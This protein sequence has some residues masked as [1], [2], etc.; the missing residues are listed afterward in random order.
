MPAFSNTRRANFGEANRVCARE[1][2]TD[3]NGAFSSRI[4]N[5]ARASLTCPRLVLL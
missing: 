2:N 4:P 1:G 5:N 3:P